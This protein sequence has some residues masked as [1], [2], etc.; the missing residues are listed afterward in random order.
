MGPKPTDKSIVFHTDLKHNPEDGFYSIIS[1]SM[2]GR[3]CH[4][5]EHVGHHVS[6]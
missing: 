6:I 2:H 4:G 1:D 5:M 3:N